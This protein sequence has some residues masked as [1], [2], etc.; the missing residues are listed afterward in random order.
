MKSCE[1]STAEEP[2]R[3]CDIAAW[4]RVIPV[5][6]GSSSGRH[7][8]M[9]HASVGTADRPPFVRRSSANERRQRSP[10]PIPADDRTARPRPRFLYTLLMADI[11]LPI[12]I[13]SYCYDYRR[14]SG[15]GFLGPS[16]LE[17]LPISSSPSSLL[18]GMGRP[19]GVRKERLQLLA[20]AHP[21]SIR[22]RPL[23]CSIYRACTPRL[24]RY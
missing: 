12:S 2:D 8:S 10:S 21:R 4:Y 9:F 19:A 17:Q 22:Q 24:Y 18:E 23:H 1:T 20:T 6:V 5:A 15:T 14:P 13:A 3:A 11:I 16:A 7:S